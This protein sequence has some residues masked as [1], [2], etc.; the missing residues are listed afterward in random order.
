LP[1]ALASGLVA[2]ALELIVLTLRRFGLGHMAYTG[3]QAAWTT[4]L[5]YVFGLTPIGLVLALVARWGPPRLGRHAV[6]FVPTLLA[7]FSVAFL[8][9]PALHVI[10]VLAL[11]LGVAV[12]ATRMLGDDLE[13]ATRWSWR[14]TRAGLATLCGVAVVVHGGRAALERRALAALPP[15]DRE[16]PSILL[17]VLDAVRASN[18]SLYGYPAPTTPVLAALGRRGVIFR[19]AYATSPWTLPSHATLVTGRYPHE[20]TA[21]WE[22]PMQRDVPTLATTLAARGYVTGGFVAN[23]GYC[24]RE[25]GL[26]HG[27]SHYQ[28]YRITPSEFLEASSLARIVV[29]NPRLRAAVRYYDIPG[30]KSAH[31]V[32]DAFLRWQARHDDRP[33]F[34]LLNLYDAH[35]PYLPPSPFDTL[36]G[37]AAPRRN[38][39]IRLFN[40]RMAERAF[41]IGMSSQERHAEEQ[42]YDGA[43]AYLDGEIGRLLGELERRGRL[44]TTVV[45]VVGDHGELFGEHDL[46]THGNSLY[47][48]LLHVPLVVSFPPAIPTNT[49][50][51]TPV[52]LR[53][54]PATLLAL[55]GSPA[56]LPGHSLLDVVRTGAAT[57]SPILADVHPAAG[58]EARYPSA[59]GVMR[60]LVTETHEYIVNGDGREEL[61]ALTDTAQAHDLAAGYDLGPLRARL[62]AAL[63]SR[64]PA[65]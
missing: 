45:I 18:L 60:A 2:G 17:V 61:Y 12:Q 22:T 64:G 29:N 9:Y 52:T 40:P 23:V 1:V 33:F 35:E 57:A 20:L 58:Q 53:D 51:E 32:A 37:R 31:D 34:A 16:A 47:L 65:R 50:V 15:A 49:V 54:L 7:A 56:A 3:W 4:P 28:D 26:D 55:A 27:F 24:G 44:A 14:L 10:A 46:F 5:S 8:F 36:F 38:E 13:R 25:T 6:V 41:K 21:G 39:L 59:R 42:A 19:R 63:A 30:R 62:R 48:P 43:I 11:S